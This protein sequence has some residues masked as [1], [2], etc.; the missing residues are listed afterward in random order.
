MST[1][2]ETVTADIAIIGG[3]MAGASA[4]YFLADDAKVLILEREAQP[5][6]HTT[7]RSAALLFEGYGNAV[8]RAITKAGRPFLETPPDGFAEA[9]ILSPRGGLMV[10]TEAQL[11]ALADG[12]R[13]AEATGVHVDVLEGEAL[14]RVA[15]FLRPDLIVRG[16]HEPG[17]MDMDVHAMLQGFLRG[18]RAKGGGVMTDAEVLGLSRAGGVWRI[19]TRSGV[20]EAPVVIN[21][22]GA[23]ADEIGAMAGA[24]RIGLVPK[25]RTAFTFDPAPGLEIDPWPL[26]AAIDESW[27]VKPDAGRVFGSPA[28]E[29][30]SA[31]CDAQPEEMDLA[32]AADRI[33]TFT[34]L[35]VRR[36]AS[37]WAGLRSFVKDKSPVA[38]F[39]PSLGGREGGFFWL[40]GQGGYGIQTA[41]GMGR[42][43]A[44][45][46]RGD[47]IPSDIKVAASELAPDR[48]GLH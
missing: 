5:G 39:E 12:V 24:Q 1:N 34:T 30:P 7:G 44:S 6:Y 4:A 15:P 35:E 9:P 40:A 10:A 29:T 11:D 16:M 33:M 36:F 37:R 23:W 2:V 45:L 26:T 47:G 20:V 19:E 18:V 48:P 22:A 21:A 17:A 32:I 13:E 38:G 42:L 3:G 27:Y 43:T 8:I 14:A 28:D 31:P 46:V 41:P 25:R